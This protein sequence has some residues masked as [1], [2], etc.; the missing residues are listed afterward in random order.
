MTT[1]RR[2]SADDVALADATFALI[3]DVFEDEYEP[4]DSVV[5]LPALLAD[6]RFWAFAALDG[7]EVVGGLTAHVVPMTRDA[8]DELFIYDVAVRPDRQRQGVGRLLMTATIAAAAAD[9]I[10][11]VFVA[12]DD[13]DEHALDFYRALGGRPGP[14]TFFDFG[15]D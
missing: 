2:L 9:G 1:I 8:T 12:A 4:R 10:D 13:D 7:D 3:A 14:A 11:V 15:A 5:G 6:D